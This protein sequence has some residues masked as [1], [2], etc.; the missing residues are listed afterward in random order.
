M[1]ARTPI[2]VTATLVAAFASS[3]P[4]RA[5]EEPQEDAKPA[6]EKHATAEQEAQDEA[7]ATGEAADEQPLRLGA[8][9]GSSEGRSLADLAGA[10][11]LRTPEGSTATVITDGNLDEMAARGRISQASGAATGTQAREDEEG[12]PGEN[13]ELQAS[14]AEQLAKVRAMEGLGATVR[15]R[16]SRP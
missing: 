4:L 16:G 11:K 1:T 7:G 5:Q 3:M 9:A 8:A 10:V 14:Y 6:R 2:L 12:T 15:A 13:P